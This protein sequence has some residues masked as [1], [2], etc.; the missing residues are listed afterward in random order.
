[1]ISIEHLKYNFL[2]DIDINI[3]KEGLIIN[4]LN[5]TSSETNEVDVNDYEVG[6]LI[7]FTKPEKKTNLAN[8]YFE[9]IIRPNLYKFVQVCNDLKKI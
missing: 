6:D 4:S 5:K 9:M 7:S 2:N 8:S 3:L 1:M